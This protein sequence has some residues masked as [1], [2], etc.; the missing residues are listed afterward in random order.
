MEVKHRE[1]LQ[2]HRQHFLQEVEVTRL[3]P[4]LHADKVLDNHE[5]DVITQESS[6]SAQ[7]AKLLDILPHKPPPAFQTLC[8]ALEGTYPLLLKEM[9]MGSP[10]VASHTHHG[11]GSQP[12]S[13]MVAKGE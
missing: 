11:I 12:V 4:F 3:L 6:T 13:V 7:M 8:V 1:L 5:L 2:L 10:P 9:F